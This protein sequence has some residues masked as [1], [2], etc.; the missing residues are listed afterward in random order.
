[1]AEE[2]EGRFSIL[3]VLR[4]YLME[5]DAPQALERTAVDALHA[6]LASFFE[7]YWQ[8]LRKRAEKLLE[9]GNESVSGAVDSAL[10]SLSAGQI[11]MLHR[12]LRHAL[13]QSAIEPIQRLLEFF[14]DR[15]A[16]RV[17]SAVV[18]AY[19]RELRRKVDHAIAE[20][21]P[22]EAIEPVGKAYGVLG[23]T[24]ESLR[25]WTAAI[26]SYR[27]C[28]GWCEEQKLSRYVGTTYHQ[29]GI[30]Y[31]EQE[32]WEPALDSYQKAIEWKTKTGQHHQLGLTRC[33]V[34]R[35]FWEKGEP[36]TAARWFLDGLRS[37]VSHGADG[38]YVAMAMSDLR[39]ALA[40]VPR[41]PERVELRKDFSQLLAEHEALRDLAQRLAE[42]ENR[43]D[44]E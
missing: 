10:A 42:T 35:L 22:Q 41:S 26:D 33:Q 24:Y 18:A 4:G 28:I 16:G 38:R 37:F 3:P 40:T 5:G 7:A 34:G 30:A 6:D 9:G 43:S 39:R 36:A 25:A 23:K 11:A 13:R 32:R 29:L 20:G 19:A 8:L 44:E 27:R 2:H 21:L 1:M 14:A 12:A 17:P 31:A 15:A